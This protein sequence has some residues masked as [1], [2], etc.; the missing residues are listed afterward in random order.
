[1]SLHLY[2]LYCQRQCSNRRWLLLL[3]QLTSVLLVVVALTTVIGLQTVWLKRL[4]MNGLSLQLLPPPPVLLLLAI[5]VASA[6]TH[7]AALAIE[8]VM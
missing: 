4:K 1:M 2:Q 6:A 8:T 7:A 5:E 3:T